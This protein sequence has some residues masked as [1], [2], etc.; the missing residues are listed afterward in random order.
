M[1][2]YSGKIKVKATN[3]G[4]NVGWVS[5]DSTT[6]TYL[7]DPS[8]NNAVKVSFTAATSGAS[9]QVE[10]TD[11]TTNRA[12]TPFIGGAGTSPLAVGS[13]S[14]IPFVGV[15]HTNGGVP[16]Q[17]GGSKTIASGSIES[18]IWKFSGSSTDLI[19]GQWINSDGSSPNTLIYYNP[20]TLGLVL[21]GDGTAYAI[22]NTHGSN[23]PFAVTLTLIA[24]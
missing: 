24:S 1:T 12:T 8:S 10:I 18:S 2:G 16:P 17:S 23:I 6:G 21:T 19:T 9:S 7:V 5:W 11:T 15:S 20:T 14:S 3:G 13:S 4:A 22:A